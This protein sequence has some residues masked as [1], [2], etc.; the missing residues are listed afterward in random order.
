MVSR[1]RPKILCAAQNSDFKSH[2][3]YILHDEN[4]LYGIVLVHIIYKTA[5]NISKHLQVAEYR[6]LF[7]SQNSNFSITAY[8]TDHSRKTRG[9]TKQRMATI[10]CHN[11][12]LTSGMCFLG[13]Q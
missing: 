2:P 11:S 8:L 10:L 3:R 12:K 13:F 9:Q 6:I 7:K 4:H 5:L 1:D